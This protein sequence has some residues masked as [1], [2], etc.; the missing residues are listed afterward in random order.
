[1]TAFWWAGVVK[2]LSCAGCALAFAALLAGCHS[3]AYYDAQAPS[4]TV[5]PNA[6][7]YSHLKITAEPGSGIDRVEVH[8]IWTIDNIGCAPLRPYSGAPITKQVEVKEKVEKVDSYYLATILDD[9]FVPGKCR[10]DGDG[11][12]IRFMHGDTLLASAGAAPGNFNGSNVIKLTCVPPPDFPHCFLRNKELFLR[13]HFKGVF[14][15]AVEIM[16]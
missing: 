3:D 6:H 10:W 4:P 13:S 16:K 1:M 9:R 2:S 7:T 8:S 14:N 11:Y 12:D 5:N 15:A